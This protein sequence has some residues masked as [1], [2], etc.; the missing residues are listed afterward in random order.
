VKGDAPRPI[1]YTFFLEKMRALLDV[2]GLRGRDFATRCG[3]AG[4]ATAAF[5]FGCDDKL[6]RRHGRRVSD[7]IKE[8]YVRPSL[9]SAL[10]VSRSLGVALS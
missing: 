8:R 3:R 4:A 2:I 1:G 6:V 5:E 7:N 9:Q 10:T